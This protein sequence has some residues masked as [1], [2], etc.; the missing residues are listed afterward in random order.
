MLLLPPLGEEVFVDVLVVVLAGGGEVV[1]L[2]V[3][4][5]DEGGGLPAGGVVEFEEDVF[6]EVELVVD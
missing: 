5:F 3:V 6:V 1:V 2:V 4:V